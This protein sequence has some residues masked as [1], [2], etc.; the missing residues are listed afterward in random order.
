ME[1]LQSLLS[2]FLH[3]D[4]HLSTIIQQFGPITYIILFFIIFCETG[5]IFMPFLPGDS[6]L[7]AVGAFT[8]KG[9]FEL[10]MILTLLSIAAIFGDSVNYKIGSLIGRRA[11]SVHSRFLNHEHLQKTEEFYERRGPS[12]IIIAR[13]LPIVRTFAPFV[14][15]VGKMRYATFLRYNIIG[16]ILWVFLF[17]LAGYFF[18]N[19]PFVQ[20]NFTYVIFAIIGVSIMPGIIEWLRSKRA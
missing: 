2:I 10:W 19:L 14:A 20:K 7:F 4:T 17:T 8:A 1:L 6:L 12:T 3:L 9:D 13:F 5:L 16:G 11:F 18:G 15:G